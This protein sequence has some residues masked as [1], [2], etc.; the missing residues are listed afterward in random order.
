MPDSDLGFNAIRKDD[1]FTNIMI[2]S[3]DDDVVAWKCPQRL[4]ISSIQDNLATGYY[5][6]DVPA[7]GGQP[8][9]VLEYW[10]K[11][12][13]GFVSIP[14][15][16][17]PIAVVA[18][19]VLW[20]FYLRKQVL[21]RYLP[22]TVDTP[23]EE[24]ILSGEKNN[25]VE[26]QGTSSA[27][28]F[29]EEKALASEALVR[30]QEMQKTPQPRP[31][32]RAIKYL[33]FG[34]MVW[35]FSYAGTHILQGRLEQHPPM[36]TIA[37][38]YGQY[39]AVL[40]LEG[41]I[42]RPQWSDSHMLLTGAWM[43]LFTRDA[44]QLSATPN[45]PLNLSLTAG[46]LGVVMFLVP[47]K[48]NTA[49]VTPISLMSGASLLNRACNPFFTPAYLAT[50][51]ESGLTWFALNYIVPGLSTFGIW[52]AIDYAK[53]HR[54]MAFAPLAYSL[55][56]DLVVSGI[57]M[58]VFCSLS[59]L[60]FFAFMIPFAA[61]ASFLTSCIGF[62]RLIPGFWTTSTPS[63]YKDWTGYVGAVIWIW[64]A[65]IPLVPY[66][67]A[68]HPHRYRRTCLAAVEAVP[69][70]LAILLVLGAP[71]LVWRVFWHGEVDI[72]YPRQSWFQQIHPPR[73]V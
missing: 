47:L 42:L 52:A 27:T 58:M 26:C 62:S 28:I 32:R 31:P 61:L 67:D 39:V 55:L 37:S 20:C 10:H 2:R 64:C 22:E 66:M 15:I 3:N 54:D 72:I 8:R 49:N 30:D 38:I 9:C 13:L 24:T 51:R 43:L 44:L 46:L 16:A 48:T 73:R 40:L 1:G 53:K 36:R 70:T 23:S 71:V 6:C 41:L 17:L 56:R 69:R 29:K 33:K 25:S 12:K 14:S 7:D 18:V 34:S 68:L 65:I 19:Y 21:A 4:F 63:P 57:P 60:A 5:D 59:C 50:A 35:C 11:Y 45:S